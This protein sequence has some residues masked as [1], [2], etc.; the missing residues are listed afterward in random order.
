MLQLI[1]KLQ[2]NTHEKGEYSDEQPRDVEETIKLIKDFPWDAERALTD[3]QLTGPSVTIQDSDLNYLKLGLYFNGKFC[4]YYLDNHNHLYEYH[5]PTIDEACTLVKVFFEQTLDLKLFD[6][7]L[8][9]IGNQPHFITNSFVYRVNPLRIIASIAA[10][11]VYALLVVFL[12]IDGNFHLSQSGLP[13]IGF[14]FIAAIGLFVGYITFINMTGRNQYLQISRGNG[15]FLYGWDEQH[16]VTYNKAD[17]EEIIQIESWN[18]SNILIKF[19]NG[20]VIQP[21][22]LIRDFDF[23]EK[24][25]EK[26]GIK[27]TYIKKTRFGESKTSNHQI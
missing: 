1:S 22:M 13:G 23:K 16:I 3:I 4:I 15:L 17:I 25:P 8:F 26:L 12:I 6:K 19:K 7:H 2:H 20:E 14:L 11:S 9:N 24:F 5:V 18:M 21:K 27:I 10:L